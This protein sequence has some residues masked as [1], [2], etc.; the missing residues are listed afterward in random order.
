MPEK[1]QAGYQTPRFHRDDWLGYRTAAGE[2]LRDTRVNYRD[3]DAG[4]RPQSTRQISDRR[5]RPKIF[6]WTF[7]STRG[8]RNEGS[9][10][11]G[12]SNVS[13][14]GLCL[15]LHQSSKLEMRCYAGRTNAQVKS[16]RS[17]SAFR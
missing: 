8:A 11:S 17:Y 5:R 1:K 16:A 4:A 13:P 2:P 6:S 9:S 3:G 7:S 14:K 12:P 15:D 10:P